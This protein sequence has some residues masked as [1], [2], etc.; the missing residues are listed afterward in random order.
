MSRKFHSAHRWRQSAN[1]WRQWHKNSFR[2]NFLSN[3]LDLPIVGNLLISEISFPS[4]SVKTKRYNDGSIIYSHATSR[5]Y[6][7]NFKAIMR[8]RHVVRWQNCTC[9]IAVLSDLLIHNSLLHR[10]TILPHEGFRLSPS[11]YAALTESVAVAKRH[12]AC[13]CC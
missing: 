2:S 13:V 11:R 1:R 8:Y 6:V 10:K 4:T 9:G 3:F 7:P 12:G 5:L